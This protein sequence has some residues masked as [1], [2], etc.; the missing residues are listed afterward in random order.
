MTLVPSVVKSS[1]DGL[2][3]SRSGR[4]SDDGSAQEQGYVGVLGKW[5][6]IVKNG[7]ASDSCTADLVSFLQRRIRDTSK[8]WGAMMNVRDDVVYW[9]SIQ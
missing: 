2:K 4:K 6:Q 7:V 1:A 8:I 3:K 5:R 9:Y